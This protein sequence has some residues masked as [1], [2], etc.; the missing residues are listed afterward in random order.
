MTPK[1]ARAYRPPRDRREV[2]LA[3]LSVLGVLVFTAVMLWVLA[4][5]D[6]SSPP[7]VPPFTVPTDAGSSL[8]AD[9]SVTTLPGTPSDTT[10][11]SAPSG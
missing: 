10:P 6:E 1:Q 7:S 9:T 2:V 3:V 5:E 11:S 4:P 8:P